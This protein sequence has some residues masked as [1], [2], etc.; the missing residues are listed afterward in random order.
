MPQKPPI[1]IMLTFLLRK[2]VLSILSEL[3]LQRHS[4]QEHVPTPKIKKVVVSMKNK[5][6][7]PTDLRSEP[8]L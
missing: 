5:A 3:P 8:M 1:L 4:H 6:E 7:R 2:P